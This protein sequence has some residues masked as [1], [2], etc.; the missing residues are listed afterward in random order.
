MKTAHLFPA[1]IPEYLGIETSVIGEDRLH[2]KLQAA[3][4]LLGCNFTDFDI[5]NNN[6]L[7]NP[8]ISQYITYIMSCCVSDLLHQSE[9]QPDYVSSFSMGIYGALYHCKSIEFGCGLQMI[10]SAYNCIEQHLPPEKMGMC[11]IGGLSLDDINGIM[12]SYVD[13]VSIVNQNSEFSFILSGHY[14]ALLKI[15]DNAKADGAMQ[16]RVLPVPHPYH[17]SVLKKASDEFARQ[18]N[19]MEVNNSI[20][21]L[22]SAMN[23]K[24]ISKKE[25]I[26]QELV[27]N[28]YKPFHWWKTFDFMLSQQVNLFIE[29]GAGES[30]YK[31]GKF[32]EGDFSVINLKKMGKYLNGLR[33]NV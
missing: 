12:R 20:Y 2:E 24:I 1:F 28:L 11:V 9:I 3:S 23:Q 25:D 18:I 17:S 7:D 32:I 33:N 31:V 15:I 5:L 16:T 27:L 13:K 8:L 26:I 10:L 6:Y 21:P 29:C 22:V 14:H 19:E 4:D 30:L